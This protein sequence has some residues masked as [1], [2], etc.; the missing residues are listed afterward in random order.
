MGCQAGPK[1]GATWFYHANILDYKM[2]SNYKQDDESLQTGYKWS[3]M[4]ALHTA[5]KN[6]KYLDPCYNDTGID[7]G[8]LENTTGIECCQYAGYL[9]KGIDLLI[10]FGSSTLA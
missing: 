1:Y 8:D 6:G 3:I 7:C 10:S 4:E 2:F 9:S 5:T